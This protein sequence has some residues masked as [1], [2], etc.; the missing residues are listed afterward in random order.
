MATAGNKQMRSVLIVDDEFLIRYSL[1]KIMESEGYSTIT[2]ESGH[3]A[4]RIVTAGKPDIVILDINLPDAN[5]MVLL[6]TI[7]KDHP[8]AVVIL[9]TG[10]P[11]EEYGNEAIRM[12]AIAYLEK[13]VNIDQLIGTMQSLEHGEPRMT[14]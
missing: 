8:S 7:K 9:A 4:L 11:E 13:P 14:A 10:C 2:A 5:G 1:Q 6:R 12:G 3:E